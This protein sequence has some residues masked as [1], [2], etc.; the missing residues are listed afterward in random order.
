MQDESKGMRDF[1][2][3]V[4]GAIGARKICFLFQYLF[5]GGLQLLFEVAPRYDTI[6]IML[7]RV[8][9]ALVPNYRPRHD[10]VVLNR[11]MPTL[12]VTNT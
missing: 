11:V 4:K 1:L 12:L 9:S 2:E 10:T 5:L 8:V 3:K 7:C 6:N